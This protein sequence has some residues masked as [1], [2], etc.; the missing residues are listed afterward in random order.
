[1]ELPPRPEHINNLEFIRI[2][3]P[4][5]FN[6]RVIKGK[7]V[8]DIG[9]GFGHGAWLLLANGAERVVAL[10]LD[11][12]KTKQVN[13]FCS[14]F[15]NQNIFVMD[16]RRLGFKDHSFQTTT[17]FEVIEHIP[18]PDL[19]LS[20][21]QRILKKDGILFLTTPNRTMR[22]LPFQRPW[23]PEHLYE[24]NLRTLRKSLKKHFPFFEILGVYG[25]PFLYEHY[26]NIWKPNPI[27]CCLGFI[28][29][30]IRKLIP[31]SIRKWILLSLGGGTSQSS[32]TVHADFLE[33][34]DPVANPEKWPFYASNVSKHCLNFFA[35]CGFDY[36]IVQT[37]MNQIKRKDPGKNF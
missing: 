23:N 18:E 30:A 21:I 16:A 31:V 27:Y 15:R 7:S 4:Y 22:L 25:E 5:V 26:K 35:I 20:E 14:H 8:L 36:E 17:C 1:M 33:K 2:L 28:T 13:R 24:Y 37:S 32:S 10:D 19:L 9:C 6:H 3:A 29:P 11:K 34:V 12:V